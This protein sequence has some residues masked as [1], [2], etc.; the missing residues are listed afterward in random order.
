MNFFGH[1]AVASSYGVEPRFVLG[2]MLPDFLSMLGKVHI[3]VGDAELG[4]GIAFHHATDAA[5]HDVAEFVRL[6]GEARSILSAGGL[7]KGAAR[8]AAHVGVELLLDGALTRSPTGRTAYLGALEHA[9]TR[10]LAI[11]WRYA[12]EEARFRELMARLLEYGIPEEA[13]APEAVARRLH[14]VLASRPRLSF[15]EDRTSAVAEWVV[16]ARPAVVGCTQSI[17]EELR[18]RLD[19]AG[20]SSA[21]QA[22]R[23]ADE[24][25]GPQ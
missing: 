25:P 17:L 2:A 1:A 11:D 9:T 19:L 5:F 21:A 20:F 18:S 3:T 13:P 23:A 24:N 7:G 22:A 4:R 10:E 8:A 12:R 16:H 15:P 14:R 6:V